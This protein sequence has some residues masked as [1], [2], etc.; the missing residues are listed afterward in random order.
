MPSKYDTTSNMRY[1]E[2][3]HM[4]SHVRHSIVSEGLSSLVAFL[5]VDCKLSHL[6][7]SRLYLSLHKSHVFCSKCYEV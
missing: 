2:N 1:D 3:M 7:L 5:G 6:N 4:T